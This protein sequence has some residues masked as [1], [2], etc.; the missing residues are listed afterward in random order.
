[1]V[2][3]GLAS[4]EAMTL[5]GGTQHHNAHY[6][7]AVPR[8]CPISQHPATCRAARAAHSHVSSA[9]LLPLSHARNSA[10]TKAGQNTVLKRV[11]D[12]LSARRV[13][14]MTMR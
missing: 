2:K 6:V 10:S 9:I 11:N 4:Y 13:P 14:C 3:A 5:Q 8:I 12:A 1:M 7:S